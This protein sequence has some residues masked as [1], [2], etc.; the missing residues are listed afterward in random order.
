MLDLLIFLILGIQRVSAQSL[1]FDRA[2][3]DYV[4]VQSQYAKAHDEYQLAKNGY[5]Q[6]KTLKL[7]ETAQKETAEMLVSRDET[8]KTYL[9]AIRT[10]LNEVEGLTNDE[11]GAF[12]SRL[13]P[14]VA[15]YETHKNVYQTSDSLEDLTNKSLESESRWETSTEQL[16]YETLFAISQGEVRGIRHRQKDVLNAVKAKVGEIETSGDKNTE[17]I[18]RWFTD[19]E[20]RF[21]KSEEAELLA[22]EEIAKIERG[23]SNRKSVYNGAIK[24]LDDSFLPLKQANDF[25]KEI[26]REIMT[27]D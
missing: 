7:Q 23:T 5:L 18:K 24:E 26:I 4:F 16:V 15:W 27:N 8:M 12:F 22:V 20:D 11:K 25:L 9:T 1:T 17:V 10:R 3:N 2:Y 13:D 19:I 21:K 14:E 6:N